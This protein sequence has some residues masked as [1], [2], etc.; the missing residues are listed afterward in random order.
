VE[1]AERIEASA[2]AMPIGQHRG[3]DLGFQLREVDHH[4][5]PSKHPRAT[6]R[7]ARP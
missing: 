5:T 3:A 4:G 6:N 1:P 7:Q 2:Q